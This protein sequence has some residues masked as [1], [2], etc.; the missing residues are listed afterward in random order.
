MPTYDYK[1]LKC[2]FK[3]E[4]YHSIPVGKHNNHKEYCLTC[5]GRMER[6][7]SNSGIH[8]KGSGFYQT[9]YKGK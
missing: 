3:I 7:P 9:D 1:C 4:M 2:D 6:V 5:S 8:F